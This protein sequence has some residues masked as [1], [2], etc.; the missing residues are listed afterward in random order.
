MRK[1]AVRS[2]SRR[3]SS[4]TTGGRDGVVDRRQRDE[5]LLAAISQ[6]D[7]AALAALYDDYAAALFGFAVRRLGDRSQAELVVQDVFTRV[8]RNARR[9][10]T[11]RG[12]VR[13]WLFAVTR[14]AVIDRQRARARRPSLVA[15]T[16]ELQPVGDDYDEIDAMLVASAV[17]AAL[18]QLSPA[19]R[20]VLQLA[21]FEGRSQA[22]IA[23]VLGV[24]VGTV[25]SR[26]YY[27]LRAFRLA[28]EELGLQP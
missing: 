11:E 13:T 28:C 17:R 10:A 12:S 3:E 22:D 18:E 14:H 16:E 1:A 6:H 24:A 7:E 5:D 9:Y 19:H 26:T 27:A 25:K 21:Y 15:V 8:W 2:I 4:T 23:A 20:Q